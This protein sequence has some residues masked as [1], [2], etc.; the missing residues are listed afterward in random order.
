MTATDSRRLLL[1]QIADKWTILI[2]EVVCT[3]GGRAR[4][5]AMRRKIDG[6][7]QK[8]LTQC[9]RRLERNGILKRTVLNTTPIG[10]EYSITPLGY[11]LEGPFKSLTEW[12]ENNLSVVTDA[13]QQFDAREGA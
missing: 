8:T 4:F 3:S 12:A 10:V 9:L 1:D 6:I 13:Q 7:S 11:S 2:L 5:N